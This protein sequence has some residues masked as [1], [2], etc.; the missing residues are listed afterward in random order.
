M[1][2]GHKCETLI[3]G[4]MGGMG[5]GG[6]GGRPRRNML[7]FL[8]KFPMLI[9]PNAAYYA[10]IMLNNAQ[11]CQLI[12]HRRSGTMPKNAKKVPRVPVCPENGQNFQKV[13]NCPPMPKIPLQL[14]NIPEHAGNT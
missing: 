4:M 3:G 1:L 7:L 12:L 10:R 13:P 2:I 5:G 8:P 11:L 9:S 6:K 14:P